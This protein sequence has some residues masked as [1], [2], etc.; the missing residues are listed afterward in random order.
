MVDAE[1]VAGNVDTV[2]EA[3]DHHVDDTV[4]PADEH[5]GVGVSATVEAHAVDVGFPEEGGLDW[6]VE[7]GE[8]VIGEDGLGLLADEPDAMDMN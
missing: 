2:T 4:A 3:G 5:A 7:E 1:G 6:G 8:G